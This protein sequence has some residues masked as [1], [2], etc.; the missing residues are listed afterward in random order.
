MNER[1]AILV[2]LLCGTDNV[3]AKCLDFNNNHKMHNWVLLNVERKN[4]KTTKKT[5]TKC[6]VDLLCT[7]RTI[8]NMLIQ[9]WNHLRYY[10]T[11]KPQQY[12]LPK[13]N[14]HL[15]NITMNCCT[16]GLIYH[17]ATNNRTKNKKIIVVPSTYN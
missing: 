6:D 3:I 16:Q 13:E 12:G 5:T 2:E 4:K 10:T 11:I 7:A 9:G 17:I 1:N 15:N 8:S 14:T